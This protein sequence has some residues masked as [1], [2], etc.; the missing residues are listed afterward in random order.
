MTDR[1]LETPNPNPPA[2][3]EGTIATIKSLSSFEPQLNRSFF[4]ILTNNTR[5]IPT[6]YGSLPVKIL[7]NIFK[8]FDEDEL[9]KVI[10]PVCQRWRYAALQPELWKT[11]KVVGKSIPTT[12]ICDRIWM[13]SKLE[14]VDI[15]NISDPSTVLRQISRNLRQLKS[16]KLRNL[17]IKEESLRRV[18]ISCTKLQNLDLKGCDFRATRFFEEL[19][20]LKNLKSINFGGNSYLSLQNLVSAAV[21]CKSLEEFHLAVF[22]PLEERQVL[23]DE[24]CTFLLATFSKV[25]RISLDAVYLSNV[26]YQ[27]LL[28]CKEL[29]Y[30]GFYGAQN[31]TSEIF[32]RT[33]EI[34]PN[35]EALKIRFPY[36]VRTED[37][38]YIFSDHSLPKLRELDLTGSKID[39]AGILEISKSCPNVS[40]LILRSCKKVTDINA[41]LNSCT[42]LAM[43]N[44]AFCDQLM[45]NFDVP[46][47]LKALFLGK[48]EKC[49]EFAENLLEIRPKLS[50]KICSSE[51]NK[52]FTSYKVMKSSE[53]DLTVE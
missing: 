38:A 50:T 36:E 21:N 23:R 32:R 49:L 46:Y 16:L 27:L 40:K 15:K 34:M 51:Y 12:K 9:I 17:A 37:V 14:H 48:D 22:D 2:Q 43:L 47:G 28:N 8:H 33:R 53:A 10:S 35:L 6:G 18:I 41:V 30:L 31:I 45:L 24:D 1:V 26:T 39:D 5:N 44:V 11:L 19:S 4:S 3:K 29:E 52:K 25:K 42:N 20:Y 7:K 13:F